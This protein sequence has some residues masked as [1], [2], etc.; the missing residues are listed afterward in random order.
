VARIIVVGAGVSGLAVAARLAARG[1]QVT[2]CES[3]AGVG[4]ALAGWRY[5]ADGE[6]CGVGF[7][8]G[9][10]TLTLPAAYRDLFIKTARRRADTA[11]TLEEVVGL[12]PLDPVRRY[13]FP[14][15]TRL[16]LPNASRARL[17]TEFDSVLGSGAGAAW[18]RVIEHG[19]RVWNT[20]RPAL[21]E[22]PGS[23]R[24]ELARLLRSRNGRAALTPGRSLGSLTHRWFAR[25]PRLGLLL[26]DYA[27][28]AGADPH[29]APAVLA[30]RVYIEHAFGSWRIPGGMHTLATALHSRAVSRGVE[31]RFSAPVARISTAGEG[32][33]VAGVV[34][35]DGSE[36]AG[37]V[38][39]AAVDSAV[40]ARLTGA[41]EPRLAYSQ[42]VTTLCLVLEPSAFPMPHE[43]VLLD[44]AGPAIRIHVPAE[45]ASAWTVH[46][47]GEQ[48]PDSLLAA[49]AARGFDVRDRVLARHVVTVADRAAA[50]GVPG[51]A[52]YGPA[53]R[54]LRSTLLRSPIA[55][56]T[57][58]L[59]HVGASA[60]PGAGLSFA[61][62]SGWQAGELIDPSG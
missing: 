45:R 36:L 50:T 21:V 55:Q 46:A 25:H 52:V 44:S 38:V 42:S 26:D 4:G 43:T 54:D 28:Q 51:G 7:D 62:L 58:G 5:D 35:D 37:D 40:L 9:A 14:D 53:P 49:I 17:L 29:H 13:V 33:G 59:Y 22:A 10:H 8:T 11:I 1:H 12:V 61:A 20:V 30:A 34:L 3:T 56:P 27:R 39:V 15:G 16:D 6:G 47:D 2:V 24:R 32:G 60:R 57:R 48:D 23:G 19:N 18:L 41:P 31:F